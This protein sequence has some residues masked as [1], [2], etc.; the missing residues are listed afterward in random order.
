MAGWEEQLPEL[1][2]R[3]AIVRFAI[4]HAMEYC[5]K[6]RVYGWLK[7]STTK[8]GKHFRSTR[9]IASFNNLTMDRARY[10]CSIDKRIFQSTGAVE[11]MWGL[12]EREARSGYEEHG[13]RA[14]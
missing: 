11:D 13:I 12:N 1:Q 5:E 6:K 7:K 14:I 4:E 9:A 2:L 8:E 10:L 3:F